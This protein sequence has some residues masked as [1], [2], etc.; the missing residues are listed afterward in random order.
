MAVAHTETTKIWWSC[1][2]HC[3]QLLPPARNALHGALQRV[4][5]SFFNIIILCSRYTCSVFQDLGSSLCTT[6]SP[7]TGVLLLPPGPFPPQSP[8]KAASP[9]RSISRCG[10][11]VHT[12]QQQTFAHSPARLAHRHWACSPDTWLVPVSQAEPTRTDTKPVLGRA[13]LQPSAAEVGPQLSPQPLGIDTTGLPRIPAPC[14]AHLACSSQPTSP[15]LSGIASSRGSRA[16]ACL[17]NS[18]HREGS[19]SHLQ[20]GPF[21]SLPLHPLGTGQHLLISWQSSGNDR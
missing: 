21:V 9:C 18:Q 16:A 5:I 17:R 10:F 3:N 14:T 20:F 4:G 15:T 6:R 11:A 8:A 2:L 13:H 19:A 7:A 1:C 12:G